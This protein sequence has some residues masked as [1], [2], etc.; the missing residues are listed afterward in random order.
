MGA[1]YSDL[2][3]YQEKLLRLADQGV[4]E[5]LDRVAKRIASEGLRILKS[6]SPVGVGTPNPGNLRRSWSHKIQGGASSRVITFK[7]SAY[8]AGYV[9]DGH[10]IVINR[11]GRKITVGYYEGQQFVEKALKDVESFINGGY[12][13]HELEAMLRRYLS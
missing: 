12:I 10:R 5:F 6:V 1:N 2:E 13:E 8:Y 9:N 3:K 7:N 4:D 11:K